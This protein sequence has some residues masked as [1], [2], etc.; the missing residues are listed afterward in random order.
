[1]KKLFALLI[2]SCLMTLN[3]QAQYVGKSH[4][5]IIQNLK[6]EGSKNI[7]EIQAQDN[8]FYMIRADQKDGLWTDIYYMDKES[9]ICTV[10]CIVFDNVYND[11]NLTGLMNEDD[12]CVKIE[13]NVWVCDGKLKVKRVPAKKTEAFS[14]MFIYS[15]Y[16]P[17]E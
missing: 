2:V 11:I 8:G 9:L 13:N 7:E 3:L 4:D 10:Y 15:K 17:E 6:R 1:M 16:E 5:W 12:T 14:V